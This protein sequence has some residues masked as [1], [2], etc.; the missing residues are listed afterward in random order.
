[1]D[2]NQDDNRGLQ[3]E[4]DRDLPGYPHYPPDEDIMNPQS[5]FKKIHADEEL[6]NSRS[7]S[8]RALHERTDEG[9]DAAAAV[10]D[11]DIKI[12]RGTEA[13]VTKEDILL[14]GVREGDADLGDDEM[15]HASA[16][17]DDLDN[18]DDLDIPGADL[19]DD[20]EDLGEEDEENNYY[21]LGGDRHESLEEDQS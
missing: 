15:V 20:K 1:M 18:E 2:T 10:D 4:Q 9:T 7:L 11:N 17:V 3:N 21:S 8:S 6:A 13:D 5:G 16:R 19:D 14:L 12:V